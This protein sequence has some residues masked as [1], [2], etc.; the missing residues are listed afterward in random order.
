MRRLGKLVER[1][2]V[3][4][5]EFARELAWSAPWNRL[6]ADEAAQLLRT[7]DDGSREVR[8]RLLVALGLSAFAFGRAVV[9]ATGTE[10]VFP[11][12]DDTRD[13]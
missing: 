10:L 9:G 3:T 2:E 5:V 6:E 11:G 8:E 1:T 4:R 13:A 7:I 12:I